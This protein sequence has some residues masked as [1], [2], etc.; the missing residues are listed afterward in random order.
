MV[1]ISDFSTF[2]Q[3]TCCYQPVV[4]VLTN[5]R[6]TYGNAVV[7]LLANALGLG[8]ALLEGVLVLELGAHVGGD[9]FAVY[10]WSCR[11]EVGGRR[12]VKVCGVV[13]SGV[14]WLRL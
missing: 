3:I 4:L 14:A 2:S 8:L 5:C 7:V 12:K 13:W 1:A 11:L 10:G 6:Q 9:K